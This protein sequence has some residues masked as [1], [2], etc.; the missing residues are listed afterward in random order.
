MLD[1]IAAARQRWNLPPETSEEQQQAFRR[2]LH[3]LIEGGE[4][5][6]REAWSSVQPD[7]RFA[8]ARGRS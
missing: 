5:D 4:S 6:H 1:E 8:R 7:V 2:R 3:Y